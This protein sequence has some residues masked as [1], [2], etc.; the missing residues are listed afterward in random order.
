MDTDYKKQQQK[1]ET[2]AHKKWLYKKFLRICLRND[3]W[4][5]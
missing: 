5:L 3:Y 4:W 1:A 2:Q